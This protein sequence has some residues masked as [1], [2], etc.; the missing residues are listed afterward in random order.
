MVGHRVPVS[1]W[2][3]FLIFLLFPTGG[4]CDGFFWADTPHVHAKSTSNDFWF[5]IERIERPGS[6]WELEHNYRRE[7]GKRSLIP[8]SLFPPSFYM[9]SI[10]LL[11]LLPS[12]LIAL[13]RRIR[14]RQPARFLQVI[15]KTLRV[16][17]LRQRFSLGQKALLPA[18]VAGSQCVFEFAQ[19]AAGL[20]SRG[21]RGASLA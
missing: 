17:I 10:P 4:F 18:V 16:H 19:I 12:H 8:L 5:M 2:P 11:P 1:Y 9:F 14:Q 20:H 21:V 7:L 3:V 13:P 15:R 6:V